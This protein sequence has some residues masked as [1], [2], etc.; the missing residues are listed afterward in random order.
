MCISNHT[1]NRVF[2]FYPIQIYSWYQLFLGINKKKLVQVNNSHYRNWNL[3]SSAFPGIVH[4]QSHC[5]GNTQQLY[6]NINRKNIF[7]WISRIS[8]DRHHDQ[9]G[10]PPSLLFPPPLLLPTFSSSSILLFPPFLPP[11]SL[12]SP[13]PSSFP[14]S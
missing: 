12:R 13:F 2:H 5:V 3:I 11:L 14:P 8:L 4:I 6:S 9:K 7:P 10:F 1:I